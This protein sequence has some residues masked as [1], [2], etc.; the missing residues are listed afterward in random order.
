MSDSLSRLLL[1]PP[2][3]PS[4]TDE[5]YPLTPQQELFVLEY[6]IDWNGPRAAKESG[7]PNP[8]T[9]YKTL[10]GK[11]NIKKSIRIHLSS[12]TN[13]E[14]RANRV[15]KELSHIAY[16]DPSELFDEN[17]SLLPPSSLPEHVT[18]SLSS[19]EVV[20]RGHGRIA[21][22][23]GSDLL[24]REPDTSEDDENGDVVEWIHKIRQHDKI[25]ALAILGKHFGIIHDKVE[26]SG[27]NGGPLQV[28]STINLSSFPL[29]L[30]QMMVIVS[31]GGQLSEEVERL[32]KKEVE[33]KFMEVG[34]L[35]SDS[36]SMVNM[37]NT[38]TTIDMVEGEDYDYRKG[39]IDE[40][41]NREGEMYKNI[42]FSK[43]LGCGPFE[44]SI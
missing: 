42:R 16:S 44:P 24:G 13:Y 2:S 17:G 21:K 41:D 11:P 10:L 3:S 39:W 12:R 32:L 35:L 43:G 9:T 30:R 6:I 29:W 15:I 14:D 26:L 27:P 36:E 37:V 40:Q 19:I 33:E 31:N 23:N 8:S 28:E 20:R 1:S 18:R 4:L 22:N 5:D 7:Y 25:K 34:V 38:M